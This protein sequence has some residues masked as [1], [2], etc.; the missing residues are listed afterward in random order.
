MCQ[1]D[2]A[3]V[4]ARQECP[5]QNLDLAAGGHLPPLLL[6]VPCDL[7]HEEPAGLAVSE[8]GLDH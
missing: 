4:Q 6:Q 3:A 1:E 8:S 2:H 7:K 5:G